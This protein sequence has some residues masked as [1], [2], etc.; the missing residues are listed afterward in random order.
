MKNGISYTATKC[1]GIIL[2]VSAMIVGATLVV[3]LFNVTLFNDI[4]AL[5][6]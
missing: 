3:A 4:S 6:Q 1:H 5:F 2:I